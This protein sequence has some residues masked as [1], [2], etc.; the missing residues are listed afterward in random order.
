MVLDSKLS[1]SKYLSGLKDCQ[2]LK[3]IRTVLITSRVIVDY[4]VD[5]QSTV[6][7]CR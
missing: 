6:V 1:P 2:W 7:H 5:G 4:L 3:H